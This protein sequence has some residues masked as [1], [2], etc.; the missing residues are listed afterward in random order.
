MGAIADRVQG[1]LGPI[2]TAIAANASFGSTR[3]Q[4]SVELVKYQLLGDDAPAVGDED[5]LDLIVQV[6]L[7]KKAALSLIPA[8][9]ALLHN[10]PIQVQIDQHRT[11]TETFVDPLKA[12]EK[13]HAQLLV[14]VATLEPDVLVIVTP[15]Q[16]TLVALPGVSD[17]SN[18]AL[19]TID[20]WLV[21]RAFNPA[22]SGA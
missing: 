6:Y 5:E 8:A 18:D 14:D 2:A 13:L 15:V 4:D 16:R 7:A 22:A 11:E 20:P 21:G 17:G 3:I 1:E 10:A 19:V 9:Y 12:L